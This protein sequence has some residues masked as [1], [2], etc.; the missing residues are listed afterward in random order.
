M[1]WLAKLALV[2]I[3]CGAAAPV[4]AQIDHAPKVQA[5]LVPEAHAI[6]PGGT[7]AIA[8]EQTIRPGWHTYWRNPGDAGQA[9]ELHWTLP[10]GWNAGPIGWPYPKELPVGPLMDYGYEGQPWLLVNLTAPRDARSGTQLVL[11]AAASWLVCKE[12]CIPESANLSLPLSVASSPPP[13]DPAVAAQFAAA[14]A[15]LPVASPWTARFHAGSTL[16]L[17]VAAP[18][19][20][21]AQLNAV[22]FFPFEDG[23]VQGIAPQHWSVAPEGLLLRLEPGKLAAKLHRL[24]GVLVLASD[25]APTQA[26][27]ISAAPG[28]VPAFPVEAGLSLALALLSAFLGGIIL[29][30]MPCV[31][32]I[33]AMKALS[34]ASHSGRTDKAAGEALTYGAG[35]VLSF[36]ALGAVVI[37]LRAGGEAIGWGFQLQQ[38]IVV[39][40]L[41][42]LMFAVGLNL[43]GVFEVRGL[44]AGESLA[45]RSGRAGAFFTGVLAVVVAAP[46]TAPFMAAALGFALTQTLVVAMLVFVALGVGFALPFVAIGLSPALLRLLPRPGGWM[47]TLRRVLAFPMY[48]TA[49]WLVWVLSFET[50][51]GR[52]VVL[53]GAALVLAFSLWALGRAQMSGRR[54]AWASALCGAAGFVALL[55][56]LDGSAPA[57]VRAANAALASQPYSEARLT[58]LRAEKRGVFVDA[59]AAWCV[60]CLV[61]EK[62]ALDD[63]RVRN[64]FAAHRV[65]FL[66]ADWTNRDPQVSAL[67][68]AHARSGV[69]LYLYYAP[70][71]ADAVVLPQILTP[72]A[73][74]N[75]LAR[76]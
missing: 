7:L 19:L 60:T 71:A 6:A 51:S 76:S 15:R 52:L 29:N 9:T 62:I 37:G 50:D 64:A 43:S 25:S 42:L 39:G 34:I 72:G 1:R 3:A 22:A 73:V 24:G 45:R 49:L 32:P 17:F 8:L 67:L 10:P 33:L 59:T 23:E 55:P 27:A 70:G 44:G 18:K 57:G 68:S 61:N 58:T 12:I 5:R 40:L 14:R 53:L 28:P 48:A 75:A 31:L 47:E 2:L 30:L 56:L 4:W 38:P 35:A 54:L 11:H 74:L 26:L 69:P 13:P 66:V 36:A 41:A 65:A 46:C 20:S 16:D 21:A 63:A